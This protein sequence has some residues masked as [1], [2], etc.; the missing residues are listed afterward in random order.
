MVIVVTG[1]VG[2]DKK[3]YLEKV[4]RLA[5][6]SG[7]NVVL[8]NVGDMMYAEAPDIAPG[9]ILDIPIKRLHSLRRSVSKTSSRRQKKRRT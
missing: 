7:K 3:N 2:L 1:M 6:S 9:K 5:E 4:C 8:C